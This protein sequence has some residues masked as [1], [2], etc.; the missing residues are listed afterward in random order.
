MQCSDSI[1]DYVTQYENNL[2][3]DGKLGNFYKYINH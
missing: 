3:S 1:K 2:I